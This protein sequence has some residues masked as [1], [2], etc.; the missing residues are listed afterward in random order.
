MYVCVFALRSVRVREAAKETLEAVFAE[1]LPPGAL[2]APTRYYC[3][4]L[5][6]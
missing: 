5:F 2:A 4:A 1:N 3:I 6:S